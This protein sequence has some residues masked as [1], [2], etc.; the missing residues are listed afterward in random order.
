MGWIRCIE[1]C[2]VTK[3]STSTV[4]QDKCWGR[5]DRRAHGA[6]E[7][8]AIPLHEDSRVQAERTKTGNQSH[9]DGKGRRYEGSHDRTS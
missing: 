7:D 9:T 4:G 2:G 6:Q 1:A 8:F 3:C 5:G